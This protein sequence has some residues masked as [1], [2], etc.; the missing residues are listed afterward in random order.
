MAFDF[1]LQ[2]LELKDFSKIYQFKCLKPKNKCHTIIYECC[3]FDE[4]SI[5]NV[6]CSRLVVAEIQGG[7]K[8]NL[9][10]KVPTLISCTNLFKKV[11]PILA[12]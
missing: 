11:T 1:G 4:K 2:T 5:S 6:Y 12:L 7:W 9:H 3:D 10:M 8:E